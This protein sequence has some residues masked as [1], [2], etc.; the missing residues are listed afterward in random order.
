[1]QKHFDFDPDLAWLAV[2]AVWCVIAFAYN[3]GEFAGAAL[4]NSGILV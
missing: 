2:F 4:A 3:A 1:M